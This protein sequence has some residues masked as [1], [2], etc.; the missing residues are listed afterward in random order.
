MI[1]PT[2][3]RTHSCVPGRDSPRPPALRRHECRRGTHECVRHKTFAGLECSAEAE[4][5]G[6]AERGCLSNDPEQRVRWIGGRQPEARVVER[7]QEFAAEFERE[8]LGGLPLL[9]HREIPVVDAVPAQRP[10]A[11]RPGAKVVAVGPE[12]R[13]GNEGAGVEPAV[14]VAVFE[15]EI[16][17]VAK[18]RRRS[19]TEGALPFGRCRCPGIASRQ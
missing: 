2:P 9:D 5:N 19:P 12:S 18:D 8:A 15:R 11:E 17:A 4:L 1:R 14:R 6:P 7:V 10:Q 3:W 13:S 16:A